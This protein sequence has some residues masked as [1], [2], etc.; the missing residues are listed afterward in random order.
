MSNVIPQFL[1]HPALQDLATKLRKAEAVAKPIAPIRDHIASAEAAY[2]VQEINTNFRLARGERLVGRKIGLTN[3]AVQKQLGVDQ[4]DYGMLFANMEV[5][6][7]GTIHWRE[8][9][10]LKVEAELAFVLNRD[11]PHPDA[12]VAEVMRAI[13]YVAP[14]FEIVGSRIAAWDI[15]FADTVADN[16]SSAYF[17]LGSSA[18][19]LA[20]ID[21]LDCRMEMR[22]GAGQVV[23]SG[24]GRD[25]L[26][27]PLSAL[28]WLARR[29]A[30]LGR[31]LKEGD[32]VLSGALG[33]M[34]GVTGDSRFSAT[35]SGFGET[36]VCFES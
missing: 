1:R 34:V 6:H 17:T 26:G 20:D 29:M 4:P 36:A 13:E 19:R 31:P 22:D 25:C 32:V 10:Q 33:P 7:G 23:S 8:G 12:S 3:P 2:A 5:A 30:E 28:W 9:A 21:L 11:L 15:R 16:A 27:S 35:I 24:T 18:R 14:S